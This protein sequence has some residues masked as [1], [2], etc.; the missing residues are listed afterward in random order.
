MFIPLMGQFP[1]IR[2]I[3]GWRPQDIWSFDHYLESSEK[4]PKKSWN[5]PKVGEIFE[6]IVKFQVFRALI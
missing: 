6:Q 5:G 1:I 2:G 4:V 3:H